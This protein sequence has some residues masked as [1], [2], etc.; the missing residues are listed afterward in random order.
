MF[1]F[2]FTLNYTVNGFFFNDS[3]MHNVYES[4][5]LFDFEY[6]LPIIFYS[7]CISMFL[8]AL[9]Q[10]LGLSN[11]TIIDFKKNKDEKDINIFESGEKLIKTLK[12]KFLLYFILSFILLLFFLFYISMFGAV[13]IN[14][15]LILIEDTLIGYGL[16]L[17]YPFVIYLL[18]G[19]FRIPALTAPLKNKKYLYNFSKLFTIL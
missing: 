3:T 1:F 14:T 4:E 18:P 11:D 17:L 12:I 8:G 19:F 5:G 15:Q 6:Q 13:Y 2:S 16:S 9:V 10:M 7:S